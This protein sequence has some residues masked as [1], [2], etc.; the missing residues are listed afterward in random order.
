[1]SFWLTSGLA[2][3]MTSPTGIKVK[4][5]DRRVRILIAD[6]HQVIRM[7]VWSTLE[8]HPHFE[9]CGGPQDGAKAIEEAKKLKPDVVVLNASMPVLDGFEADREIKA[10]LPRTAIVILTR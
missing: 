1:M 4:E 10:N 2:L 6:D 8:R 3:V 7:K 9:V 5:I